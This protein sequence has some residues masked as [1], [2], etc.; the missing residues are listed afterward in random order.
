VQTPSLAASQ[1]DSVR[2]TV[3]SKQTPESGL[4]SH[5]VSQLDSV[6]TDFKSALN[7]PS[8]ALSVLSSQIALKP[9]DKTRMRLTDFGGFGSVVIK[10]QASWLP[11]D[12]CKRIFKD[13]GVMVGGEL[14]PRSL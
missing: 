9:V 10:D 11:G 4:N 13:E 7:T 14:T 1:L 8:A 6:R 5:T 12:S 3:A 2:G